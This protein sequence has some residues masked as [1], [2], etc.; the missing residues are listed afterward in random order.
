MAQFGSVY[1]DG[2]YWGDD[3]W[4]IDAEP[5]GRP[6]RY[7]EDTYWGTGYWGSNYWDTQDMTTESEY[8]GSEYWG[9][10]FWGDAYWGPV[11][12][13]PEF[14][15][16]LRVFGIAAT[17]LASSSIKS[18]VFSSSASAAVLAT[19]QGDASGALA[20]VGISTWNG[21]GRA[22]T[23]T[24]LGSAG[25]AVMTPVGELA[26]GRLV[27]T[28]TASTDPG[29]TGY[30]VGWDTVT[31]T[32]STST[33]YAQ[34]RD[35]GNVTTY[36]ITGLIEGQRY[37]VGL[38]SHGDGGHDAYESIVV[39]I[40]ALPYEINQGSL[41]SVA[42]A[43][44]SFA[45]GLRIPAVM[46]SVG[47]GAES[48]A[49]SALATGVLDSAAS[50]TTTLLGDEVQEF[51]TVLSSVAGATTAA[52]GSS[53]ASA[54]LS[55]SATAQTSLESGYCTASVF[56]SSGEASVDLI[57]EDGLQPFDLVS[58]AGATTTLVGGSIV[59]AAMVSTSSANAEFFDPSYVPP[60]KQVVGGK[61]RRQRTYITPEDERLLTDEQR[62]AL[63][64]P[65]KPAEDEPP[66]AKPQPKRAKRT[67]KASRGIQLEPEADAA[68]QFRA[69][70]IL[71]Q[72]TAELMAQQQAAQDAMRAEGMAILQAAAAIE[73]ENE[74]MMLLLMAA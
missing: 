73:A 24:A 45:G 3:Y 8:F 33:A 57:G 29:V 23:Q 56:E 50:S 7:F 44:S 59:A 5:V 9:A 67:G 13:L 26:Q 42:S 65:K 46:A 39:E 70:E 51:E 21:V 47:V 15:G 60:K 6:A 53:V 11:T 12:N 17:S 49:A 38:S 63:G 27:L 69:A 61:R 62:E 41:A 34:V 48:L 66:Q 28:W 35:V 43:T 2:D 36:T 25:V 40:N 30:F 10:N 74:L 68:E 4:G 54:D 52:V 64:L 18:A 32:G 20:S 22:T 72:R 58:A 19:S 31:H 1:Y 55:S 14:V 71:A 16:V 37:Y